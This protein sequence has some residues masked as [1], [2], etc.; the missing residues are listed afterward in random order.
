MRITPLL[1]LCGGL[2]AQ[3]FDELSTVRNRQSPYSSLLEARA[4]IIGSHVN[5]E[6]T[7]VGLEDH[8]G[9]DGSILYEQASAAGKNGDLTAYA[10]RDGLYGCLR[11]GNVVGNDTQSRLEIKGR[12]WP[13]YRE[14]YYSG[15]NFVPTG[16]YRGRDFEAYLG[17]GKPVQE[18]LFLEFGPFYRKN[19]FDSTSRTAINYTIPENYN[20]YGG[21]A[22]LEQNNI[23]LDRNRGEPREGYVFTLVGEREWNDSSGQFGVTGGWETEL[24]KAVWRARGRTEIYVPQGDSSTWE[25]FATGAW[26]DPSDRV[27]E[28][29]AQHPQGDLWVDGQLRLRFDFGDSF[30]L[31][32]FAQGQYIRIPEQN[33]LGKDKKTFLGFGVEATVHFSQ[34]LSVNGWYSYL[35][36]ESRPPVSTTDDI[37]GQSMFFLGMVLRIGSGSVRR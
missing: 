18:G 14:G 8:I 24:P 16:Q 30:T 10:G 19:T 4:G 31:T 15:K 32:P 2:A 13:F 20:A 22:F 3:S 23:K 36:N 17:F 29:D 6:D 27:V 37:H 1:L 33:G 26:L 28:F 34:S 12:L 25:I 11:N 7:T 21:R 9:W 5:N 35:D